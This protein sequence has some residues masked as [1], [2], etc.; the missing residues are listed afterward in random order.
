MQLDS[1]ACFLHVASLYFIFW[2]LFWKKGEFL[3]NNPELGYDIYNCY[4]WYITTA[5]ERDLI[6]IINPLLIY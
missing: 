2:F 6:K 4:V 3:G 5:M 1:S